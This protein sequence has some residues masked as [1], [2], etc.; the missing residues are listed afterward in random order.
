MS[1]SYDNQKSSDINLS[2]AVTRF[3]ANQN[4]NEA[5]SKEQLFNQEYVDSHF[6]G[7][8]ERVRYDLFWNKLI[9][10]IYI[11]AI[12]F[13]ILAILFSSHGAVWLEKTTMVIALFLVAFVNIH[14]NV[15]SKDP[16]KVGSSRFYSLNVYGFLSRIMF[17]KVY[18][19]AMNVLKK[20]D[21]PSDS[22]S[23]VEKINV[24]MSLTYA[25]LQNT[26]IN[27][28][29]KE[30]KDLF[31]EHKRRQEEDSGDL[32][33]VKSFYENAFKI[34]FDAYHFSEKDFNALKVFQEKHDT[35]AEK[36]RARDLI[37]FERYKKEEEKKKNAE[38]KKKMIGDN[39]SF[40]SS[41]FSSKKKE[42]PDLNKSL[43]DFK[44]RRY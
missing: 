41:I 3:W 8:G 38:M 32:N 42:L 23:D 21:V 30:I 37:M 5:P 44:D 1:Y 26:V 9:A 22:S 31:K 20:S 24:Y 16:L 27:L 10:F 19:K 14:N 36:K 2:D 40:V 29:D 17:L 15:I 12:P 28:S 43:G 4:N 6:R 34:Y 25:L 39:F 11:L 7:M 13:L 33:D 35:Y 18:K